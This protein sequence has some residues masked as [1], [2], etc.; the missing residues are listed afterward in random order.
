MIINY[1]P[2]TV[3]YTQHNGSFVDQIASNATVLN[4][5]GAERF[6]WHPSATAGAPN[7]NDVPFKWVGHPLWGQVWVTNRHP[8]N[9]QAFAGWVDAAGA[10]GV[11][12]EQNETK[13]IDFASASG[14]FE[15]G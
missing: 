7:S 15:L 1:N 11:T 8:R 5:S 6:I 3:D 13:L 12:I 10:R 9:I 14:P 4:W 2:G